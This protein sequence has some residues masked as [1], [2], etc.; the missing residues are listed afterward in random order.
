[1]KVTHISLYA[2]GAVIVA[3]IMA[4]LFERYALERIKAG[5]FETEADMQSLAAI[6][7]GLTGVVGLLEIACFLFSGVMS[8]RF[9]YAANANARR[10]GADGLN[11]TPGWA[12]GWYFV[13]IMN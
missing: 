5:D 3:S 1:M 6:S 12:V 9:I 7:D 10:L 8:L 13:P 4:G 11:Y 2:F